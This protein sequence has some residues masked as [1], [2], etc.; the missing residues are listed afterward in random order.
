MNK[1]QRKAQRK[2]EKA[3]IIRAYKSEKGCID[4]GIK[5]WR[6]L[7]FDHISDKKYCIVHM[8]RDDRSLD[9]IFAEIS[10]CVIR[11]RNCHQI[12][13]METKPWEKRS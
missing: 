1:Q 5:D 6:V 11:C 8:I 4:C 2:Q 10:K 12:K 9:A 3:T 13:T 7:D